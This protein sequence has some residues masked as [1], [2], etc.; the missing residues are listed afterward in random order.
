[1]LGGL[2]PGFQRIYIKF[3]AI[4][5]IL[6]LKI[7]ITRSGLYIPSNIAEGMEKKSVK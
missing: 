4:I 3:L 7:Q 6:A 2:V 1:M 5:E